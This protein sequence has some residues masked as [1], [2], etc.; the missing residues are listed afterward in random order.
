MFSNLKSAGEDCDCSGSVLPLLSDVSDVSD[1]GLGLTL[2]VSVLEPLSFLSA[3]SETTYI[4]R[5]Y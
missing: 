5:I 4:F 1:T 2:I 3:S